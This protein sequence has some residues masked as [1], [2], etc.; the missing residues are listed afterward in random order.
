MTEYIA[1]GWLETK[2]EGFTTQSQ[3]HREELKKESGEDD[4]AG[5]GNGSCNLETRC[6][7]A[8][9]G[10]RLCCAPARKKNKMIRMMRPG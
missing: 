2:K 1:G 10:A 4:Q 7:P 3:R 6:T 9:D 5:F 8:E